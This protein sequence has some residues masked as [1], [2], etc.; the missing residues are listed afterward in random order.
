MRIIFH[1]YSFAEFPVYLSSVFPIS[2]RFFWLAF[3][4]FLAFLVRLSCTSESYLRTS[5]LLGSPLYPSIL[6]RLRYATSHLILIPARPF[7]TFS[8][9]AL[10]PTRCGWQ[11]LFWHVTLYCHFPTFSC[12]CF[13]LSGYVPSSAFNTVLVVVL[14]HLG[15]LFAAVV[16]T[17]SSCFTKFTFP[18]HTSPAYP[19]FG[20]I[21]AHSSRYFSR[22]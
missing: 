9:T 17:V 8:H 2:R 18:S 11:P 12:L 1:P 21:I 20:T 16:C 15:I 14:W 6:F 3:P 4:F 19:S 7:A 5:V 22:S 13:V 10:P